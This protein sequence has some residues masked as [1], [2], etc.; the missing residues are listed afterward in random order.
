MIQACK[1]WAKIVIETREKYKS[2]KNKYHPKIYIL[3]VQIRKK[4]FF[5][6]IHGPLLSIF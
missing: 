6:L 1:G 5:C 4:T 3:H 2:N